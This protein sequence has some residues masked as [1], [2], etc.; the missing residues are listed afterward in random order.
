M[1]SLINEKEIGEFVE[2]IP[3]VK[4]QLELVERRMSDYINQLKDGQFIKKEKE[5]YEEEI[6]RKENMLDQLNM[7]IERREHIS[8]EGNKAIQLMEKVIE[9]IKKM[10]NE[11]DKEIVMKKAKNELID[12]I[13]QAMRNELEEETKELMKQIEE[14]KENFLKRKEQ[15]DND[16]IETEEEKFMRMKKE[17]SEEREE[18]Q[19]EVERKQK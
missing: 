10:E 14:K 8:Q 4:N 15:H 12:E 7:L 9:S 18:Y 1:N 3:I 5:T 17:L 19:K 16:R 13:I 6:Q 11:G 2:Q